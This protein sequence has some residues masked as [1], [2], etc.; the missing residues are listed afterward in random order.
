[1]AIVVGGRIINLP[2]QDLSGILGG[3]G[4]I[5]SGIRNQRQQKQSDIE[6]INLLN[7]LTGQAGPVQPGQPD[8]PQPITDPNQRLDVLLRGA[9]NPRIT[10][11]D[12]NRLLAA[13]EIQGKAIPTGA[14]TRPQLVNGVAEIKDRRGKVI[15][16]RNVKVPFGSGIRTSRSG[17]NT[18]T[19][20][21]GKPSSE[22]LDPR[23][24]IKVSDPTTGE[25]SFAD[26][27][28]Q[29]AL[30][31]P[32]NFGGQQQPVTPP[33]ATTLSTTEG[34]QASTA[35]LQSELFDIRDK[36]AETGGNITTDELLLSS[37]PLSGIR[38]GTANLF[39]GFL[40]GEQ[41]PETASARQQVRQ[42]N[43]ALTTMIA[44]NKR[45]PVAER[46]LV[47]QVTANPTAFFTDPPNAI[48]K[49]RD[50]RAFSEARNLADRNTLSTKRISAEKR[51]ELLDNIATRE[52][53][54]LILPTLQE[55]DFALEP[56]RNRDLTQ[57]SRQDIN[58][59]ATHPEV[60]DSLN[61]KQKRQVAQRASVLGFTRER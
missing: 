33:V 44:N 15:S 7:S 8:L 60:A 50:F 61:E 53:V 6:T 38:Q 10:Q 47:D 1:M 42:L 43:F 52:S 51:K 23:R 12:K 13:A 58:F 29:N 24:F 45:F 2:Q 18:V 32:I 5:V 26:K 34:E 22:K 57:L 17:G 54:F 41:A 14:T 55:L 35:N 46:K 27:L 28:D 49:V 31:V 30:V 9:L 39:G 56:I 16:T 20:T 3:L 21:E 40:R 11:R 59:I 37:G 36:I 19:V 4:Q 25:L 48:R